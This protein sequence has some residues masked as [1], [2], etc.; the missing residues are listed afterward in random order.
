MYINKLLY[1]FELLKE[2]IGLL[3]G[4]EVESKTNCKLWSLFL[5]KKYL[6]TI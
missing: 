6:Q 4:G 5:L 2:S 1:I 3:F